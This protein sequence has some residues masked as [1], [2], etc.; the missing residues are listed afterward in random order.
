ML[1]MAQVDY[2]NF[3]REKEGLSV[4]SLKRWGTSMENKRCTLLKKTTIF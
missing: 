3:L 4:N 2:I 1:A